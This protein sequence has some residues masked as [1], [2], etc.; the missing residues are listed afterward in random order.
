MYMNKE[1]DYCMNT[2]EQINELNNWKWELYQ[3][4]DRVKASKIQRIID[5]LKLTV[6]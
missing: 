1:N 5:R 6:V 3:E 2:W 4:G